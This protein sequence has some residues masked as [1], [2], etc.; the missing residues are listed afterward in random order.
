[1]MKIVKEE[2]ENLQNEKNTGTTK[3]EK[4]ESI[5]TDADPFWCDGYGIPV[6]SLISAQPYLYDDCDTL[7]KVPQRALKPVTESLANI[8]WR[9]MSLDESGFE[10]E[11]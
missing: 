1:M 11:K 8:I 7:D 5:V 3:I 6:V 10:V 9:F 4:A 2:T